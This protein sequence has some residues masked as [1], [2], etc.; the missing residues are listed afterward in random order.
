M[1]FPARSAV[2]PAMAGPP[3]IATPSAAP[4]RHAAFA[5][6]SAPATLSAVAALLISALLLLAVAGPAAA[7]AQADFSTWLAGVGRE[8]VA[9]GI[10]RAT[11]ESALQGLAPLPRVL[12]LDQRQ[13]EFNLSFADYLARVVTPARIARGRTLVAENRA[14]LA[15]VA[16]RYHVPPRIIVALWGIESDFGRVSGTFPEVPALA[17]LAYNGRRSAYFRGE[18]LSAL[19]ILDEEHLPSSALQGSWAGAIGQTQFMPTAFL[20]YAVDFD[21]SGRRDIWHNRGDV[22]ASAANYLASAGWRDGETWGE[23]VRLPP[24]FD[25][26][27]AGPGSVKPPAAWSRLG[28]R[29]AAG[30]PLPANSALNGTIVLPEGPPGPAYLVF[31]NYRVLMRWNRSAFFVIAAGTLADRIG[32]R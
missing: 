32:D 29:Q 28:V 15:R 13:P 31:D 4:S 6:L 27:L 14:L 26:S 25:F 5:L 23:A 10:S 12:E 21:H 30:G 8:A 24:G 2:R 1:V 16:Q 11:V 3:M 7:A 22:F 19:R 20:R 17:T 9:Q 18:L